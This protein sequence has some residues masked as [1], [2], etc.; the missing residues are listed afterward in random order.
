MTGHADTEFKRYKLRGNRFHI[1]GHPAME[2]V[3]P[4]P[5]CP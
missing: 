4:V 1:E 5:V 3:L 2:C